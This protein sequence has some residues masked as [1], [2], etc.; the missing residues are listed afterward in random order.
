LKIKEAQCF[1]AILFSILPIILSAQENNFIVIAAS[2]KGVDKELVTSIENNLFIHGLKCDEAEWRVRHAAKK[3]DVELGQI[4][5]AYG[6]YNANFSKNIEKQEKCWKIMLTIE[7]GPRTK[8]EVVEV[9]IEGEAREDEDFLKVLKNLPL[10]QGDYLRHDNYENIKRLI[11][12]AAQTRGYFDGSYKKHTLRVNKAKNVAKVFID[13]DSGIRYRFGEI[14]YDQVSLKEELFK[15]YLTVKHGDYYSSSSIS[16]TYQD[17]SGSGYYADVEVKALID[18]RQDGEV[19]VSLTL[20]NSKRKTYS[21]GVG[22]STDTGPRFRLEHANRHVNRHG[23][24][25]NSKLLLSPV[26]SNLSFSYK[27]PVGQPQTDFIGL[28]IGAAHE[29]TDSAKSDS[30][31]ANVGHT[32]LHANGWLEN[33]FLEFLQED[34]KVGE[35]DAN[36]ALL[37][38]GISWAKTQSN[39]PIYP[40]LGYH[41]S[42]ETRIASQALL[43][44]VDLLQLKFNSKGILPLGK[45]ARFLTRLEAGYNFVDDFTQ[46]PASLRFFAG[47]DNSLRGYDYESLGPKDRNGE[48]VG[49]K[50]AAVGSVEVDYLFKPKWAMAAFF[51]AGNAFDVEDIKIKQSAGIGVRWRSPIGPVKVDVAFPIDDQEADTFRLHFSLGPEL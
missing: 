4:L 24:N 47:G 27:I 39:N 11:E 46:L 16:K 37:M 26:I 8:I 25:Y 36:S 2:I 38:P 29:D 6:Y 22:A 34:F 31:L 19:P 17:L 9:K 5:N 12:D 50:A 13:Y 44:D 33:L 23:H 42:L 45:K 49:G 10:K 30:I 3:I 32:K 1:I 21:V 15:K 40:T 14:E 35:D 20:V 18:Q 51:D 28:Q 43:S 41:L 7:S 48:V